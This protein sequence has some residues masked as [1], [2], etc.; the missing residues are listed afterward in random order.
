MT[1]R[2]SLT[3]LVDALQSKKQENPM[4]TA[5]VMF[6]KVDARDGQPRLAVKELESHFGDL[7]LG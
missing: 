5:G 1:D 4:C 6:K 7:A 3:V 2:L